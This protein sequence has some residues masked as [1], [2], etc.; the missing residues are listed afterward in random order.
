MKRW[1]TVPE[2]MLLVKRSERTIYRW[3]E[4]G[5]IRARRKGKVTMLLAVDVAKVES[6]EI[7]RASCRERVF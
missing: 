7:G 4:K 2:A 3:V 5:F 1:L 6:V